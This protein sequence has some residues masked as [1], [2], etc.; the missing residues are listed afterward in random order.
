MK[1]EPIVIEDAIRL[2]DPDDVTRNCYDTSSPAFSVD[3]PFSLNEFR[4]EEGLEFGIVSDHDKA[5]IDDYGITSFKWYGNYKLQARERFGVDQNL[6]DDVADRF[7]QRLAATETDGI[8]GAVHA[9]S[10]VPHLRT[11]DVQRT[12]PRLDRPLGAMAVAHHPPPAVS[13]P[14]T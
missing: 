5:I 7:I 2:P 1:T 3:A 6:L 12:D 13:Q 4:A 8:F 11:A 9:R 14:L 10:P